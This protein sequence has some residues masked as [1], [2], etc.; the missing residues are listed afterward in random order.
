MFNFHNAIV[1]SFNQL[2]FIKRKR[3]YKDGLK[4]TPFYINLVFLKFLECNKTQ[5]E[6]D[7]ASMFG[8]TFFIYIIYFLF[9]FKNIINNFFSVTIQKI[10]TSSKFKLIIYNLSYMLINSATR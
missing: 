2:V 7:Q 6:T 1:L 8:L 3:Y 10:F 9:L 5:R 4:N